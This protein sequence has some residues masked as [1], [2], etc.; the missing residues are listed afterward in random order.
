MDIVG[1]PIFRLRDLIK[2]SMQVDYSVSLVL[3][4]GKGGPIY[5]VH[6]IIP[7]S[8]FLSVSGKKVDTKDG[9]TRHEKSKTSFRISHNEFHSSSTFMDPF[10]RFVL[11]VGD[12]SE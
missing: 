5:F 8:F 10:F 9:H 6:K 3:R 1:N 7:S 11:R 4:R 2:G 12:W